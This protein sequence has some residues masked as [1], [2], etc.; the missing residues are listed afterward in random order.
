VVVH[1]NKLPISVVDKLMDESGS[2]HDAATVTAIRTQVN[3]F[4]EF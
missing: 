4:V 3:E 2:L 1:P